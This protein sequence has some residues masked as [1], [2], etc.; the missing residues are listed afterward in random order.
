MP[1]TPLSE[2]EIRSILINA[3]T[4]AVVGASANVSRPSHGVMRRLIAFGYRVYPVNPH[5]SEV[6]GQ[7]AYASLQAL[8]ERVDIVDVFRRADATPAIADEAVAAGAKVL[9]L[10]QGIINQEAES[11]ATRGGLKVIMDRCI[12]VDLA[13]L[14]IPARR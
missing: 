11:R 8:P 13:M 2:H 5:E 9:W 10:Q 7:P 12:A 1:T 3:Q 4:I 14:R 6:L